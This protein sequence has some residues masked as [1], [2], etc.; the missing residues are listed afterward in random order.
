[1]SITIAS[2]WENFRYRRRV[3]WIRRRWAYFFCGCFFCRTV[4]KLFVDETFWVSKKS[5]FEFQI[6]FGYEGRGGGVS[7][8]S[9]NYI[10]SH[11]TKKLSRGNP[12]FQEISRFI[13]FVHERESIT[14]LTNFCFK[15]P[16]LIVEEPFCVSENFLQ[17]RN[18]MDKG[19]GG[20]GYNYSP[21]FF[22]SQFRNHS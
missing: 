14:I 10:L 8:F 15:V 22:V 11:S 1:M 17:W 3:L 13:F 2:W 5:G 12:V 6:F 7:R 4:P 20:E 19:V 18:F 16:Q 9:V 21:S